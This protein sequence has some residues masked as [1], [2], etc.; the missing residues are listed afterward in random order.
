MIQMQT[1]LQVADNS[2][3]KSLLVI[4][5]LGQQKKH[6]VV[7]DIVSAA[8]EEALPDGTVKKGQ[9]VK[10]VI[11]RSKQKIRRADGSYLS[12]D[13]NAAAVLIDKDKNPIGS[14]IFGPVARE[15]RDKNFMKIISLA[16][17][18]L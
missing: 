12:F 10:A 11:V 17:E 18:V 4:T 1:I 2:G 5:V 9:R 7:G 16:P 8:V 15:L 13:E 14:R 3:A 6:A